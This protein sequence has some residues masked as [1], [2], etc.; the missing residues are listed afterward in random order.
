MEIEELLKEYIVANPIERHKKELL[1]VFEDRKTHQLL[2]KTNAEIG[3][4]LLNAHPSIKVEKNDWIT[5]E[6][7]TEGTKRYQLI[8]EFFTEQSV[9][10][11]EFNN[12]LT[13]F[14]GQEKAKYAL[15]AWEKIQFEMYQ[16]GYVRR[17]F[18]SPENHKTYFINQLNF[19]VETIPQNL[20]WGVYPKY[21]KIF[22]DLSIVQQAKYDH[23]FNSN[24]FRLWSAALDLGNAELF[25]Q[26]EDII[27]NKDAVGKVTRSII[28]ALLNSE[29]KE[30]WIL[31]EKLLLAAQRQEGLRQTIL[32]ALDETSIG[33][34]Q[35]MIKVIIDNKLTRFSSV[36]RSVDVWAGLGWESERETTVKNFLEKA[37]D[38]LENPDKIPNAVKSENNTDVYMALWSQ[39]VFDVEKTSPYLHELYDTGN[40]EKRSLVLKF[41][42][43]TRLL[44][45]G[46]S[47]YYKA[48]DGFD[49]LV[50]AWALRGVNSLTLES[51]QNNSNLPDLFDKL[52]KIVQRTDNKEKTFDGKIFS[53]TKI[54][55]N[56][57]EALQ[58]MINLIGENDERLQIVL[59]YFDGMSLSLREQLTR[60]I[61]K[62]FAQ[63]HWQNDGIKKSPTQFQRQFAVRLLSNKGEFMVSS[64]FK[65]LEKVSF[66]NDEMKVLEGLLKR[67]GANFR[68]QIIG[69]ILKQS[70]ENIKVTAENLLTVG[71][72]EQRLAGLDIAL[73]LRKSNRLESEI[74]TFTENFQA[75]KTVSAK[76]EILLGQLTESPEN[77]QD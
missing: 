76:E 13:Y 27:F 63:Y 24:L 6:N 72:N 34:L 46:M 55:F 36:V 39:G 28:K 49:L 38:F 14:F 54:A 40:S 71:D 74:K 62:E 41:A 64:A 50:L 9:E 43:E 32:E 37:R 58:A 68:G 16:T 15:R 26:I 20:T 44:N 70:D 61:L 31:V 59:G 75:R 25:R 60:H 7:F 73:Q 4:L 65:T 42:I 77:R 47:L 48:L 17:S 19:L 52:H 29:K 57:N 56:R 21:E 53:W 18:R 5:I 30:C 35:Y 66:T 8:S 67:K 10:N 1:E 69:L 51:F 11:L 12:L 33:A 23:Y 2:N 3:L 45:L 22:F